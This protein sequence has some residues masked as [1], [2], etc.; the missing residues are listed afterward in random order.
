MNLMVISWSSLAGVFLAPFLYGLFWK[1]ATK[2]G[3]YAGV[4]TGLVCAFVLFF[5]WGVMELRRQ[6]YHH[7]SP[8]ARGADCQLIDATTV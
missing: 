7:V 5:A 2:A 3:V 4:I 6:G 8:H 1:R